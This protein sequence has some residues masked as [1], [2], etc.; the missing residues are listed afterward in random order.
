MKKLLLIPAFLAGSLLVAKSYNYEITP[1]IGYNMTEDSMDLKDH[2]LYGAQLQVNKFTK[3][4]YPEITMLYAPVE[5][6]TT[7]STTDLFR[8]MVNGVYE[9]ERYKKH[10]IPTV[11]LGFGYKSIGLVEDATDNSVYT[12]LGFGV[13][14]PITNVWNLKAEYAYM[15]DIQTDRYDQNH[16]FFMGVSYSFGATTQTKITDTLKKTAKKAEDIFQ[17]TTSEKEIPTLKKENSLAEVQEV[18]PIQTQPIVKKQVIEDDDDKDGVPNYLDKCTRTPVGEEVDSYGCKL[19]VDYDM[20]GIKDSIDKCIYTPEGAEVYSNGCMVD[21]DSD[22]DG[23]KDSIDKCMY[24]PL[25]AK[26]YTNGCRVDE[27][28]D[29]DGIK[30]SID[31]C[32][33]TP[34]NTRV[35]T[36]GCPI[37][38]SKKV[39]KIVA[40][41]PVQPLATSSENDE[42]SIYKK[43]MGLDI[44]FKYK[45]FDVTQNSLKNIK[46]LTNFL[47]ENPEYDVKVSGYTDNVGSARYNKK[48]S[49]KRANKVKEIIL[50]DGI[51]QERVDAVG[52][53]EDNPIADNTTSEGRAKNRRIE[54]VLIKN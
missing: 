22:E 20:D 29:G 6:E 13:K 15:V 25:N 49:Q 1:V 21:G 23:I 2:M 32:A 46:V 50:E 43:I 41:K 37:N 26:V 33:N 3:I 10:I 42:N 47:N 48:L 7:A 34:L 35:K 24:T 28:S 9:Y 14:V 31:E 16:A 18:T 30:D 51:A 11:K 39:K 4:I 52:M 8:V 27:D 54:F 36:N 40:S 19:D 38:R 12:N 45:S 17:D 5:Y 44:A 53:G